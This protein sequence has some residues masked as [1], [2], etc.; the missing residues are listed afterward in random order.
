[1]KSMKF[2]KGMIAEFFIEV[3]ITRMLTSTPPDDTIHH[4][5]ET[6]L[7]ISDNHDTNA[8]TVSFD[9]KVPKDES[10]KHTLSLEFW[11]KANNG[12]IFAGS[13]KKIRKLG[14]AIIEA[15]GKLKELDKKK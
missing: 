7:K 1:M 15:A 6:M 5:G 14:V 12:C 8:T 4:K 2:L 11:D 13:H 3:P 10:G 9:Y